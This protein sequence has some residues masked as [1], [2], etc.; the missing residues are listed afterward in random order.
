MVILCLHHT[1]GFHGFL[2]YHFIN[3]NIN[4]VLYFRFVSFDKIKNLELPNKKK[5]EEKGI[6]IERKYKKKCTPNFVINK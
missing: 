3:L 6:T 2:K 4:I 5:K 1:F